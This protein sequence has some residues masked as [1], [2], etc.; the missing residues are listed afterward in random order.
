MLETLENDCPP[1]V[2]TI[3]VD[4]PLATKDISLPKTICLSVLLEPEAERIIGTLLE[5]GARTIACNRLTIQL[6]E[7]RTE[8]KNAVAELKDM[9]AKISTSVVENVTDVD[10]TSVE[11]CMEEVGRAIVKDCIQDCG[12]VDS[13]S[14]VVT[15]EKAIAVLKEEI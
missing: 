11:H 12:L 4:A 14:C 3:F 15:E 5:P 9:G 10:H 1:G 8:F 13:F 7:L 2:V 6:E